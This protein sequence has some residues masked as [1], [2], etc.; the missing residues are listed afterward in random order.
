MALKGIALLNWLVENKSSGYNYPCWGYPFDWNNGKV[1]PAGTPASW[2][3][4]QFSMLF[5]KLG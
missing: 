5:G 1:I 2:L 3:R 4:Q